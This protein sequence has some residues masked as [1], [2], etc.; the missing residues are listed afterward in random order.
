MV[1][2]SLD[3]SYERYYQVMQRIHRIG[4][5]NKC[6][7]HYLL[8]TGTVDE[9]IHRALTKKESANMKMVEMFKRLQ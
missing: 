7:Y 9:P 2:T 8:A 3:Y 5:K 4:Q 1:F 6:T